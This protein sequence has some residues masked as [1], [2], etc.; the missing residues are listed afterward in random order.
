MFFNAF[1]LKKS[2]FKVF[3]LDFSFTLQF[4][5]PLPFFV[6]ANPKGSLEDH[7]SYLRH[8]KAEQKKNSSW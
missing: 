6:S 3:I 4:T 5:L 1:K 7:V 8:P 2:I